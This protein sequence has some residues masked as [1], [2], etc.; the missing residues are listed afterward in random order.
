VSEPDFTHAALDVLTMNTPQGVDRDEWEE[1]GALAHGLLHHVAGTDA[2]GVSNQAST[3]A[4]LLAG[5]LAAPADPD[6]N[7][8]NDND[9][10]L[11][12]ELPEW[13]REQRDELTRALTGD[14]ISH[15]WEGDNDLIVD[16]VDQRRVDAILDEAE[17]P[18]E[19]VLAGGTGEDDYQAISDLFGV[20]DRL[21]RRPADKELRAET[22]SAVARLGALSIPYGVADADWWLLRSRAAALAEGLDSGVDDEAVAEQSATLSDML[23][24][25]L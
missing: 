1:A 13:T 7:G 2:A 21:A 19:P 5:W 20:C 4:R 3:L 17:V 25:F 18:A 9:G 12:Y 6:A 24:A 14:G 23:R 11:V 8:A 22:Q 10:E 16:S 15:T